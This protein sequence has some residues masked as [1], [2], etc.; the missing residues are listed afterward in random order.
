MA[1]LSKT[2]IVTCPLWLCALVTIAP[3]CRQSWLSHKSARWTALP[4]VPAKL[5]LSQ[6]LPVSPSLCLLCCV[7]R[8]SLWLDHS[9]TRQPF[10]GFYLFSLQILRMFSVWFSACNMLSRILQLQAYV[11]F[12]MWWLEVSY[13]NQCLIIPLQLFFLYF[14]CTQV[15]DQDSGGWLAGEMRERSP[16]Q[17]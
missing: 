5:F 10:N 15:D 3:T 6:I 8:V 2:T 17:S 14:L 13:T 16:N 7:N 4:F 11:H 12:P 9:R 1:S